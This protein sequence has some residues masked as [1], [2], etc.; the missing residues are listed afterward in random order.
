MVG[1]VTDALAEAG[2]QHTYV[3]VGHGAEAVQQYLGE[4]VQYV[5][6]EEQLGTG[7]AVLQAA[8][9]LAEKRAQLSSSAV[10]PR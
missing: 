7:H 5:M 3:V 6:Q 2:I 10:I 4:R 9:L 8:S 1:H